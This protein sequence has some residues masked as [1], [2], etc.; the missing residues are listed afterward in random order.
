MIKPPPLVTGDTIGIL[1]TARKISPSELQPAIA[2]LQEWGFKVRTAPNL[3]KEYRQFAGT[4]NE[5]LS[6]LQNFIND[7]D[8]KAI[9]CVRGG[10]G[11]VRIIDKLDFNNLIEQPKWIAGYSDVTVLHNQL[12]KMGIESLHSTMPINFKSNTQPALESLKKALSGET[13]HYTIPAHSLNRTGMASGILTGGNLSMLYSQTGSPTALNTK[14]HL[15]F[16]EDLDEYLY[17]IDRMMYNLKRNGYFAKPAGVIIGGMSDMN[18][19]SIPFGETAEEIIHRHLSEFSYP[20]CFG[21]PAGH[22]EDNRTLIFGRNA[23]F[24]VTKNEVTL[25]FDG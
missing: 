8:I 20:V 10:Y 7:P 9:L 15:L 25:T 2:L 17:H 12:S 21:F 4:D 16:L 6:D 13:L 22:L 14:H 5:R 23:T 3:F 18:D 19:N 11:T 1:S 24:N